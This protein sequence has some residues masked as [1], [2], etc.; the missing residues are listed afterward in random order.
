MRVAEPGNPAAGL[1][2]AR[3]IPGPG[4]V[5]PAYRPDIDLLGRLF[6]QQRQRPDDNCAL[7]N[8]PIIGLPELQTGAFRIIMGGRNGQVSTS[9]PIRDGPF[10]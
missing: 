7:Q 6:G 3:Q 10:V 1:L 9:G 5:Q 8:K 4:R 2:R